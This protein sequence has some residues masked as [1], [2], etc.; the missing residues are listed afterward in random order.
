[1]HFQSKFSHLSFNGS[2][3]LPVAAF[4]F[5]LPGFAQL[6]PI[7]VTVDPGS[8]LAS[9]P[10]Q[11]RIL[12]LTEHLQ[13]TPTDEKLSEIQTTSSNSLS[14]LAANSPNSG[15]AFGE[16]PPQILLLT[17]HLQFTPTDEKLSEIETTSGNAFPEI[18]P[19]A[20]NSSNIGENR[21]QILLL[22]EHLQS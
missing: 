11:P 10:E 15:I 17:E 9:S 3:V 16:N 8:G 14:E 21:P 20:A 5:P 4:L 22:T 19:D 6:S 13:F 12:L 7:E 2:L 18:V 1:M